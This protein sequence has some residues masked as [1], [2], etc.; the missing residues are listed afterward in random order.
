[1]T[2]KKARIAFVAALL[3]LFCAACTPLTDPLQGEAAVEH[4]PERLEGPAPVLN[5]PA[6]EAVIDEPEPQP[7]EPD[8]PDFPEPLVWTTEPLLESAELPDDYNGLELPVQGA[9]GYASIQLPLWRSVEDSAAAQ[10]AVAKWQQAKE[11]EKKRR[12]EEE[13][14]RLEEARQIEEARQQEEARLRQ[15]ARASQATA[16]VDVTSAGQAPVLTTSPDVLFP[17]PAVPEDGQAV[18]DAGGAQDGSAASEGGAV[19]E[20][21]ANP[22]GAAAPAESA[23]PEGTAAPDGSAVPEGT[24]APEETPPAPAVPAQDSA[25]PAPEEPEPEGPAPTL[26][27]GAMAILP[28]GTPFTILQEAGDWW[29]VRCETDYTDQDGQKLHGEAIGWVEHRWC[30]I[31]L[32]DVIPS[33]L[34]DATNGYSSR[35]VSC[36]KPL[37]GITGQALYV[38]KTQNA[39]LGRQ[40][41]MMPVLYAM[42][43][44]LCAAQRTALSEGN[45]LVLYEGYRPLDVQLKVSGVLRTMIRED[46]EVRAGV[47]SSPWNIAWFIA[48]SASNHQHGYA[49]DVSLARVG[50]VKECQSGNYRYIHVERS[51]LYDMPTVIHELSRAA[52]TFTTPVAS[53]S[54]NAW[55]S[56]VLSPGMSSCAPAQGLQKYCTDAGLT[57]LASEWWHFNDLNARTSVLSQLGTGGFAITRCRSIAP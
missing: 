53:H 15:E 49:V 10:S 26:T 48:T 33:I 46:A 5:L 24:A 18:P 36:G 13:A 43:F 8:E 11:A 2:V 22:E 14:R 6:R 1:M 23:G 28:A 21:G 50:S 39:R 57:P 56:A 16:A 17:D 52:A 40:E 20:G 47:T 4:K 25:A 37:E 38:G 34:Y 35:F 31:N 29:K 9:T 54:A 7:E 12:E 27:D 42:A 45:C 44:R 30:M 51:K 3:L 19:P 55:K 32:P 41:F